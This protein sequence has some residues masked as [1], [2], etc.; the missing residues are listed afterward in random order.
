MED[1]VNILGQEREAGTILWGK[2]AW[3]LL[4]LEEEKAPLAPRLVFGSS[5]FCILC[6]P[7]SIQQLVTEN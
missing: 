4:I 3:A 6:Q 2:E 5:T 7:K 1:P